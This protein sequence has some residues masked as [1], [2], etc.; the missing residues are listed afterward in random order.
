MSDDGAGDPLRELGQRLDRARRAEAPPASSRPTGMSAQNA[1]GMAWRIGIE[2]VVAIV[3]ATGIGWAIDHWLGTRPWAMIVLFFL[4]VAAGMVNVW[5][6]VTGM[7][8]AMG[9]GKPESSGGPPPQG[10]WDEDED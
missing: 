2:L 4:G 3:V 10:Q 1:L 9:Y 6:A 7:S 8:T 5:R